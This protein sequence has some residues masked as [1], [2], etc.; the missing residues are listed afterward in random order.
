MEDSSA[1]LLPSSHPLVSPVQ[2]RHGPSRVKTL[3]IAPHGPAH[4]LL[5]SRWWSVGAHSY[6][7][8]SSDSSELCWNRAVLRGGRFW[9]S[10]AVLA[11]ASAF[12]SPSLLSLAGTHPWCTA[13][14][15]LS[16]VV[17]AR[18]SAVVA[19]GGLSLWLRD[20]W[21]QVGSGA[22]DCLM[23]RTLCSAGRL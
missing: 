10:R 3:P 15:F 14:V 18:L 5:G 7:R 2:D 16:W 8:Q 17:W 6:Q 13:R 11:L 22:E 1:S 23:P 20:T 9:L 4:F 19:P 12:Y 21:A